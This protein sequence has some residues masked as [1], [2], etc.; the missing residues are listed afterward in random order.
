MWKIQ[1][2]NPMNNKMVEQ[3]NG[4]V[5]IDDTTYVPYSLYSESFKQNNSNPIAKLQTDDA[6]K[7]AYFSEQNKQ[8][9]QNAIRY[10]VWINSEKEHI[11]DNQSSDE[12]DLIMRSIYLQYS[13]N[14]PSKEHLLELNNMVVNYCVPNII[15]QIK[16][17]VGYKRDIQ[18]LADPIDHGIHT[19]ITGSK[20]IEYRVGL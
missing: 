12:L 11:I 10:Q 7:L 14:I 1:E 15:T 20:T 6:L 3:H 2:E 4:R 13:R 8:W 18:N 17:Y 19:R 9:I 16:Q 5:I